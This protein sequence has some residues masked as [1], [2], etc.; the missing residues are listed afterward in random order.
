MDN[1]KTYTLDIL[2]ILLPGGLLLSVLLSQ[3]SILG[4]TFNEVF[5]SDMNW[6]KGVAFGGLAYALGHFLFFLGSFLDE[7]L[8]ENVK[9][10]FWNDHRL[11]AYVV[12]FKEE[13]T[14]IKDRK[15]L[16]AFKWSCAWLLAHKPEMYLNVERYIAE[17]KFFRSLIVTLF[18]LV[19]IYV[20]DGA[21]WIVAILLVL[22]FFSVV[23]Y[24]TQRQK[25]I[26]TAYHFVITA[27]GEV[28]PE[29]P[30]QA[31]LAGMKA[32]NIYPCGRP[33]GSKRVMFC[34]IRKMFVVG[35]LFI[36]SFGKQIIG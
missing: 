22:L 17:S 12:A 2:S 26:E 3:F 36:K 31:I 30:D 23:R 20:F 15:V 18:T 27:S 1:L 11:V 5:N 34:A 6:T 35:L 21:I 9:R 32:N 8:Y 16:N 24:S 13:M 10:V 14:G 19:L 25:S 7:L 4:D 33:D 29:E 28:F